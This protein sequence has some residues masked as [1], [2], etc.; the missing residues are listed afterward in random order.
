MSRDLHRDTEILKDLS[1]ERVRCRRIESTAS[2]FHSHTFCQV[3]G[4][5][6]VQAAQGSDMV[7]QHL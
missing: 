3:P 4:L 7:S 2:L 1:E 6:D 5:I